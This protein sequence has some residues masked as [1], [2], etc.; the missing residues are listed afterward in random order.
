MISVLT[1]DII[2]S[3]KI[4]PGL[5]LDT[6]KSELNS[7]GK[8]PAYWEIYGGDTFQL[9]V[10]DPL[11]AL[12][13][14]IKLKSVIKMVVPLDV[15][16]AIGIGDISFQSER[17]SECNGTAFIFSGEKFD[18]LKKEK[19][20]MS[21][22]SAWPD[23]DATINLCLKL[24]MIFM[25]KWS[26]KASEIIRLSLLHPQASQTELGKMLD[27]GQNAISARLARAHF[28]ELMELNELYKIKLMP[29]L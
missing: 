13:I 7:F 18:V 12:L 29:F 24:G 27:I 28:Y 16:L 21:I 10:D 8:N 23:F 11:N 4:A 6:L 26:I 3:R 14:A 17:I 2:N 15:R 25:D 5:W 1:G 20:K 19:L 9:R 22:K